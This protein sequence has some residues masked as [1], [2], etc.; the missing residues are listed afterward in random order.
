MKRTRT[1]FFSTRKDEQAKTNQHKVAQASTRNQTTPN[2]SVSE[3]YERSQNFPPSRKKCLFIYPSALHL[4]SDTVSRSLPDAESYFVMWTASSTVNRGFCISTAKFCVCTTR[5]CVS[6]A[7][8][9][10][11]PW[12]N[13]QDSPSFPEKPGRNKSLTPTCEQSSSRP[14]TQFQTFSTSTLRHKPDGTTR[15]HASMTQK[16]SVLIV[17]EGTFPGK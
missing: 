15:L 7:K 8:T 6:T 4:R 5:K 12:K 17:S 16:P 3:T 9:S 13:L 14:A 1:S 10:P 2:S 11:I